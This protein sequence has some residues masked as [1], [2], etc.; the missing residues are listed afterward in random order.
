MSLLF[1]GNLDPKATSN[2]YSY[3]NLMFVIII[4]VVADVVQTFEKYG[5]ILNSWVAQRPPGFA[6]INFSDESE[7]NA[8]IK[9][10][11]GKL[12]MDRELRVEHS[13]KEMFGQ[14][15]SRRPDD[16]RGGSNRY[17]DR[18]R[19]GS[20]R[21]DDRRV[22]RDKDSYDNRDRDRDRYGSDRRNDRDRYEDRRGG[23]DRYEDDRRRPSD[24][25]RYEDRHHSPA[26]D[27]DRDRDRDQ[28]KDAPR[29]KHRSSSRDRDRKETRRDPSRSKSPHSGDDKIREG[30][31][32]SVSPSV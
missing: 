19:R 9:E 10:L 26:R 30:R 22:G 23:G 17:D 6:F 32:R 18:D 28:E 3:L 21:Y 16:R 15:G 8:A 5:K 7:A 29:S 13:T 12:F 4:S 25:Y 20:D 31:R 1:I 2:I 24:R 14:K 11:N 27:R